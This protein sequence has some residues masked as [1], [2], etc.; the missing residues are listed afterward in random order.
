MQCLRHSGLRLPLPVL[1]FQRSR[2][3]STTVNAEEIEFFSKLSSQWWD[4]RGEFAMLH[5][6]NPARVGFIRDKVEETILEEATGEEAD[7]VP[8]SR[9]RKVLFGMNA[10]DIGC[11]GGLLSEVSV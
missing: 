7:S 1:R 9:R 6:M 11:G 5:R 8:L 10:L 3:Y 2:K 4:E